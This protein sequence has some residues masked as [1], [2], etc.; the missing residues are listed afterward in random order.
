MALNIKTLKEKILQQWIDSISM[1]DLIGFYAEK[2][3]EF[4]NQQGDEEIINIAL[5]C[6]VIDEDDLTEDKE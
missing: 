4:L 6:E 5:D 1:D 3:E 2:Q